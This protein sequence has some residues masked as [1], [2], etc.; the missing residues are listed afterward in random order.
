MVL[1]LVILSFNFS[2]AVC[3]SVPQWNLMS[4][5]VSFLSGAVSDV[6]RG[7]NFDK[8]PVMPRKLLTASFVSGHLLSFIAFTLSNEGFSPSFVNRYP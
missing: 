4:F 5:C 2:N 3:S 8:Y 6:H 7:T 1:S